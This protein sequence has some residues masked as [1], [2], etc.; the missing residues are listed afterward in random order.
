MTPPI[1]TDGHHLTQTET[2]VVLRASEVSMLGPVAL[3]TAA[4]D[5][6]NMSLFGKVGSPEQQE[7]FLK[8]R[9]AGEARSAFFMTE[10]ASESGAGSDPSIMR[11]TCRRD[12]NHW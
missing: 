3:N 4:P 7:L 6:G 1:C 2:A 5:E 10:P 8:P 9:V 11:T 12:G